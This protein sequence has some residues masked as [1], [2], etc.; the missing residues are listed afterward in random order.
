MSQ[1]KIAWLPGDGIGIEVL[2]ATRIVLDKLNLDADYLHGDIGWDC[3]CQE[4]D[5]FPQRTI[6][7]LKK[8]DAAMF[9]AITS[10]PT[11][12]ANRELSSKHSEK[13]GS[14]RS[15][16]VKM[17]QLF[18]LYICLRPCKAFPKN[19]LNTREGINLT[20]FR[21]NT[22][23]LYSGV[24]F[25]PVPAELSKLLSKMSVSFLPFVNLKENDFAISVV[26]SERIK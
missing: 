1:Y 7:L 25:Y 22:E 9:G 17:R 24:E 15:P 23:D 10:K 4:G 2:Q 11:K 20:I 26:I 21:E 5:P 6:E 3:W 8:V 12:E 13:I 18:D 16:I 14:Y 19:P